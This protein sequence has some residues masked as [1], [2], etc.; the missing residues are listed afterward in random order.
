M[1]T[2]INLDALF[3]AYSMKRQKS[4]NSNARFKLDVSV[5]KPSFLGKC[6]TTLLDNK[7]PTLCY[8]H[9]VDSSQSDI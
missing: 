8:Q 4:A 1:S 9:K 6:N 7:T 5:S 2:Y 3:T